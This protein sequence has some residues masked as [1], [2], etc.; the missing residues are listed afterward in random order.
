MP[1]LTVT[2][3][4]HLTRLT[5]PQR[6]VWNTVKGPVRVK[7]RQETVSRPVSPNVTRRQSSEGKMCGNLLLLFHHFCRA[8]VYF[9]SRWICFIEMNH[10]ERRAGAER[11]ADQIESERELGGKKKKR[12]FASHLHQTPARW[13]P[14]SRRYFTQISMVWGEESAN[15]PVKA[16]QPSTRP[17]LKSFIS[18]GEE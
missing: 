17:L 11:A 13:V 6:P 10:S 3:I 8:P 1:A 7:A 18:S 12:A 15:S 9:G 14:I 2:F 16:V 5:S 4:T